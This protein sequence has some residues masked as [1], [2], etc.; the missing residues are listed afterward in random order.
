MEN[1]D[2]TFAQIIKYKI[3][4]KIQSICNSYSWNGANHYEG[5]IKSLGDTVR[6]QKKD[7]TIIKVCITKARAFNLKIKNTN[8]IVEI[9]EALDV[10]SD[11]FKKI[12]KIG[13]EAIYAPTE[14]MKISDN[15]YSV[16][17]VYEYISKTKNKE[18]I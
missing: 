9:N 18:L 14:I 7:G 11:E 13:V 2:I 5:E 3:F 12:Y 10:F 1:T 6:Y 17:V 15:E 4:M 16:L 8:D